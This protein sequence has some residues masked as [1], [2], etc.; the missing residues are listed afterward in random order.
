MLLSLQI[1][2]GVLNLLT[3]QVDIGAMLGV[4]AKIGLANTE[5]NVTDSTTPNEKQSTRKT[6]RSS[7]PDQKQLLEILGQLFHDVEE[8]GFEIDVAPDET[9]N[10][11]SVVIHGVKFVDPGILV[12][13][14]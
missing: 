9:N 5:V 11:V 4:L 14:E 10:T 13:A 7:K 2:D 12:P 1:S 3:L 6:R 8:S